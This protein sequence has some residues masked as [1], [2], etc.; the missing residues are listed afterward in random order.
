MGIISIQSQVVTGHVGNSAAVFALQCRG[1]DVWPIPTVLLSHHP[2]H[3]GAQGGALPAEL[4][5]KLLDG[6]QAHNRFATCEAVISGYLGGAASVGIVADAVA[7]A[8][9]ANPAAVYLCDPVL[10]DDGRAYVSHDVATAM[11]NLAAIAAILTPNA[12][13]LSFLSGRAIANRADALL[14]MRQLKPDGI[15]VLTSF[16]GDDTAPDTIDV[17]ATDGGAAWRVAV[18]RFGEN[19][20]GC[21]D[22]FAALFLSFWLETRQTGIALGRACAALHEVLSETARLGLDELALVPARHQ[23]QSPRRYFTPEPM[24]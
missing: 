20:S 5:T 7:R 15:V 23:M 10:G 11:H 21:G 17:L 2:G 16:E 24:A 14:A 8:K 13:E 22:V 9:A 6:M 3:G 1:H 19:F 12:Y 4:L 18:P